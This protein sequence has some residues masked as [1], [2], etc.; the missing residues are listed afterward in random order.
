MQLERD[1]RDAGGAVRAFVAIDGALAGVI[2]YADAL[3]PGIDR[4]IADTSGRGNS[5]HG[6][7]VR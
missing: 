3:R 4:L 5:P 1:H 2:T 7:A 6:P